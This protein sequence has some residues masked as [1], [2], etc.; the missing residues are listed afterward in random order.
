MDDQLAGVPWL[1]RISA[2]RE[3]RST[4]ERFAI[5]RALKEVTPDVV[6]EALATPG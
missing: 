4:V 2:T 1:S 3:L 5:K 6:Q